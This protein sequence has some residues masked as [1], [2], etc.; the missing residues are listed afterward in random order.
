MNIL[1]SPLNWGIGHATRTSAIIKILSKE[2][3]IF[4]AADGSSYFFLQKEF[5]N[6]NIQKAPHLKIKYTRQPFLMP[7]KALFFIPKLLLFYFRNRFWLN[8]FLRKNNIDLIISD[9]RFGFFSKKI[10]SIFITHQIHIK[11]PKYLKLF[12]GIIF[13]INKKN[14][15]KFDE[16]WIADSKKYRIAGDLS[17]PKGIKIPFY[18]IGLLSRFSNRSKETEQNN[19]YQIVAVISGPEPQRK[20]LEQ[21]LL[22]QF[23]NSDKKILLI[24]G[25]PKEN[26]QLSIK[27]IQLITHTNSEKLQEMLKNAEIIIVRA[28]YSTIMDLFKIKRSA[29]LIP[30]PG[31]TEQE[32]LANYLHNNNLFYYVEQKS[33]CANKI[34]DFCSRQNELQKNIE[35]L[36]TT[37]YLKNILSLLLKNK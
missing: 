13:F 32:Y 35:T 27:N 24:A 30:T 19:K 26:A 15:E 11:T 1:I 4:I 23:L 8:K 17:S 25:K 12:E 20:I 3:N 2:H 5:P 33:L 34:E 16:L 36:N 10:K 9:N 21:K 31:Q 18:F 37:D 7:L 14:I 6:I 22:S 28:G 29:I